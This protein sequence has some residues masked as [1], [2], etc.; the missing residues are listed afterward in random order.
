MFILLPPILWVS[1]HCVT[2]RRTCPLISNAQIAR[3]SRLFSLS[4]TSA[5]VKADA[6]ALMPS[7]LPPA[8]FSL[9]PCRLTRGIGAF[10]HFQQ[11]IQVQLEPDLVVRV[12]L[13]AV[14][15]EE[16]WLGVSRLVHSV[17]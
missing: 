3:L 4:V 15:V 8:A 7:P 10:Q 11:R 12:G 6:F 14:V 13:D 1:A 2:I 5:S 16:C 17:N 9:S